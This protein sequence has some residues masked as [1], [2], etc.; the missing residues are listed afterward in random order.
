MTMLQVYDRKKHY[1]QPGEYI[2]LV[3]TEGNYYFYRILRDEPLGMEDIQYAGPDEV[4][5]PHTL[6][7]GDETGWIN[8][9]FLEP[10]AENRLYQ[11]RPYLYM[12]NDDYGVMYPYGIYIPALIKLFW[13]MPEG[14]QRGGTARDSSITMNGIE[15]T[16]GG[17]GGGFMTPHTIDMRSDLNELFDI[18]TVY[19]SHPQFKIK[20]D[21]PLDLGNESANADISFNFQH[22][23]GL[24]G[25]KYLVGGITDKELKILESGK[26]D[27]RGRTI[28]GIPPQSVQV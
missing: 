5:V 13:K 22:Y 17:R 26:V 1:F 15:E 10:P 20:N 3:D 16:I 7:S 8:C 2:K 4:A 27:F 9:S 6:D 11:I 24:T 14:V 19:G 21:S 28:G 18:F 25:R 12:V 23:L